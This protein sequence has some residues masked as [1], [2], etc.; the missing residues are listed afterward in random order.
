MLL[1]TPVFPFFFL[2]ASDEPARRPSAQEIPLSA[3]RMVFNVSFDVIAARS[4]SLF[5]LH[6]HVKADK[7]LVFYSSIFWTH[8]SCSESRCPLFLLLSFPLIKITGIILPP[9]LL[10]RTWRERNDLFLDD[11]GIIGDG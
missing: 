9:F 4:F 5:P 7:A 3:R 10:S 8:E 11:P 1:V 6:G 2:R